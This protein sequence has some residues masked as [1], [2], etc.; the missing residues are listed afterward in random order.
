MPAPQFRA[1]ATDSGEGVTYTCG[2]SCTP[3]AV[4]T[5]SM[6][7]SEHCCCGKVHFAGMGAER[8]LTEYLEERARTRKREPVYSRGL[9]VA[10]LESGP[11][12]VAWAFPVED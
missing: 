2:C 1:I 4:P 6:P 3:T 12:E 5:A 11:V 10:E 9:A 7:G 8:A